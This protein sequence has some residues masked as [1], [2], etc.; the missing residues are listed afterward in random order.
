MCFFPFSVGFIDLTGQNKLD[1]VSEITIICID[2]KSKI[3]VFFVGS[4]WAVAGVE[5]GVSASLKLLF[6]GGSVI[7]NCF[8]FGRDSAFLSC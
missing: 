3:C 7:K 6:F 4:K 1:I 5:S 8:D 2:I